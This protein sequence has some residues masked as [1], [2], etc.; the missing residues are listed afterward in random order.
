MDHA[1]RHLA[2]A[3]AGR[4][5]SRRGLLADVCTG[6]AGIGLA[7]LLADDA[8]AA[9]VQGWQPGSGQTHHP[10]KAQAG[11][12]DLLPRGRL[13]HRPVGPQARAGAARR[14]VPAG[15][16]EPRHLPGRER[17][18]DAEPLAVRPGAASA[19]SGSATCCR[20]WRSTSTTSPSSTRMTSKT[21][22]HGPG[23]VFMNTGHAVEGFPAAGA[24]VE[25]RA[26]RRERGPAGLRRDPRPPRR[27]AQRQGELV[28]RLPAGAASG[29][30]PG[31]APADPQPRTAR[32]AIGAEEEAAT[33]DFLACPQRAARRRRSRRRRNSRPGSPPTSWPRGC[34]SPRRRWPTWPASRARHAATLRHGRPEPAQGGVRPQLPARPPA[35]GAGRAVRQP[36]LRVAGVGRRRPAQLGRPQ[37]AQGRLRAALPRSSTSRPPRC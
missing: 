2:T 12:A 13:A 37:D 30:R 24:W 7:H 20:T 6:L 11:P 25:L 1:P 5:L 19:A 32:Q 36:V 10:A 3:V 9:P 35:A 17:Q 33:R 18:P 31:G 14:H 28:E 29:D 22:T 8:A 34:S 16:G 15:R 21:N 27:A 23:C 4:I 26:R